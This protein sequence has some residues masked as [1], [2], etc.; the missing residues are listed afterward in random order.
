MGG[1]PVDREEAIR[2]WGR[3]RLKGAE[4]ILNP[5]NLIPSAP[6]SEENPPLRLSEPSDARE[7]DTEERDGRLEVDDHVG[8]RESR[9]D[10]QIRADDSDEPEAEPDHRM[11]QFAYADESPEVGSAR[12]FIGSEIAPDSPPEV[13][14]ITNSQSFGLWNDTHSPRIESVVTQDNVPS[15]IS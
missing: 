4:V 8:E 9:S 10:D 1:V 7:L 14:P 13:V 11:R 6:V 12:G 15:G 2:L 5:D 3:G